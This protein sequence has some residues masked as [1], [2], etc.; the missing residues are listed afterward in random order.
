MT[1]RIQIMFVTLL[2]WGRV[3]AEIVIKCTVFGVIVPTGITTEMIIFDTLDF[4]LAMYCPACRQI[5]K[6]TRADAWVDHTDVARTV[7]H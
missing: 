1:R 7:R 5:H 2:A 3:M 4:E 6:W